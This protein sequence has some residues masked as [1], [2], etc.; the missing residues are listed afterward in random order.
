MKYK[1]TVNGMFVAGTLYRKGETFDLDEENA[2]KLRNISPHLKFEAEHEQVKR[3]DDTG[4]KDGAAVDSPNARLQSRD[5]S[6]EGS[7]KR[8]SRRGG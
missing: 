8:G 7:K 4:R 2:D 1:V 5:G 6:G 3:N